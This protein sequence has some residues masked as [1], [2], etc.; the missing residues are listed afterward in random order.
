MIPVHTTVDPVGWVP[1]TCVKMAVEG[2]AERLMKL[3]RTLALYFG[4]LI[5][6]MIEVTGPLQ[7]EL[8]RIF[9]PVGAEQSKLQDRIE[10]KDG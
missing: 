5:A 3:F 6:A 10:S 7:A 8:T 1:F 9:Q 2:E 4:P